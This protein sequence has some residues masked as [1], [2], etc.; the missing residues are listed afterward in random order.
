MEGLLN[1]KEPGL[2]D[3]GNSQHPHMAKKKKKKVK[4]KRF[5]II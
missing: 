4:I 2:N 5:I 3:P 1:R